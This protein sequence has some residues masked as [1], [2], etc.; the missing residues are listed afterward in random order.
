MSPRQKQAVGHQSFLN[1]QPHSLIA[2][3]INGEA[4]IGDNTANTQTPK[5]QHHD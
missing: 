2:Y 1:L 5:E 3:G 4:L